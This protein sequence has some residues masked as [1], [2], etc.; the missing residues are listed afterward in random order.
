MNI[1]VE[2]WQLLT[3]GVGLLLSFFGAAFAAG[4][5]LG[6]QWQKGLDQRFEAQDEARTEGSKLFRQAL[7]KHMEDEK[8]NR[9]QLLALERE[10]LLWRSDLP[11]KHGERLSRLEEAIKSAPTNEDL[12]KVYESVNKLAATVNQLVGENRGQTDTLRLILK[13]ITEKGMK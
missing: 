9:A 3:F 4:K 11:H 2:L 8:I 13:Q 12:A 5:L 10:F 6:A 7:D 1:Q